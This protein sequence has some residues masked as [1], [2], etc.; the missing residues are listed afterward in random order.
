MNLDVKTILTTITL[1]ILILVVYYAVYAQ[2]AKEQKKIKKMQDDLKKDDKIITYSGLSGTIEEVLED[3]VIV[4]LNPDNI[5][6]SIEKWA[7]AG[8]D[9]R[10]KKE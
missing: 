4:K 8:I 3:R 9:D 2:R 10:S 7:V 1:V 6:I 5:K